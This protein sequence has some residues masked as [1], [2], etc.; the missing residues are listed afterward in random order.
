MIQPYLFSG[1]QLR[2]RQPGGDSEVLPAAPRRAPPG[3]LLG[4]SQLGSA[5][6]SR[7]QGRERSRTWRRRRGG[8]AAAQGRLP[9]A[10][11]ARLRTPGAWSSLTASGCSQ[12]ASSVSFLVF[13]WVFSL[14]RLSELLYS[15]QPFCG[16]SRGGLAAPASCQAA[17]SGLPGLAAPAPIPAAW[18]LGWFGSVCHL[19]AVDCFALRSMLFLRRSELPG[20]R[21]TFCSERWFGFSLG[22]LPSVLEHTFV[23]R[24]ENPFPSGHQD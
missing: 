15:G 21:F 10:A 13:L 12:R 24:R 23:P 7:R 4:R 22:S 16:R 18:S 5:R 2:R 20:T 1:G 6:G 17:E 19:G 11:K 14:C 9:R 8:R 3:R